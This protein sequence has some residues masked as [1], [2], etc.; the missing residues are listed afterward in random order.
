MKWIGLVLAILAV[1]WALTTY[2][3][4]YN[5]YWMN[6]LSDEFF[7]WVIAVGLLIL[8]I[9]LIK[10]DSGGGRRRPE[11]ESALERLARLPSRN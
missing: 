6:S 9:V 10:R 4:G 1:L 3:L 8:V 2:D 5:L 11:D 7:S